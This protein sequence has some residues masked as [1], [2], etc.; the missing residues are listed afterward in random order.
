MYTILMSLVFRTV[1]QQHNTGQH[2]YCVFTNSPNTLG[3]IKVII[4]WGSWFI[5]DKD[6]SSMQFICDEVQKD[7][8]LKD[9]KQGFHSINYAYS[10]QRNTGFFIIQIVAFIC[11]LHVWPVLG[12]SSGHNTKNTCKGNNGNYKNLRCVGLSVPYSVINTTGWLP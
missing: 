10:V 11:V 2:M 3:Q 12:P 6:G 4:N 7:L 1:H 8:N 5:Q 9:L